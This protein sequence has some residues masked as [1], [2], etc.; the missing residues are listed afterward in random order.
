MALAVVVLCGE[1]KVMAAPS[2]AAFK[3]L[4]QPP[5]NWFACVGKPP[6]VTASGWIFVGPG[7]RGQM[8]NQIPY[9]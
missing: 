9:V 6:Q 5:V 7:V 3:V 2:S 4:H 8:E 1:L